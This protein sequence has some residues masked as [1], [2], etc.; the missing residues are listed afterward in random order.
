MTAPRGAANENISRRRLIIGGLRLRDIKVVVKP[1]AVGPIQLAPS[2]KTHTPSKGVGAVPN[3][4]RTY[5]CVLI[6]PEIRLV[7]DSPSH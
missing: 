7:P 5:P 3:D 6:Q 1:S 2:P 4:G